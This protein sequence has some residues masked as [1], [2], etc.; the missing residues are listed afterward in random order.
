MRSNRDG[1]FDTSWVP[2]FPIVAHGKNVQDIQRERPVSYLS[3]A[4]PE[5]KQFHRYYLVR[6]ISY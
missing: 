3:M 6:Q 1:S 5:S 2:R 4:V